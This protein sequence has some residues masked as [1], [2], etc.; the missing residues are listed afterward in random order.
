MCWSTGIKFTLAESFDKNYQGKYSY[1]SH[2]FRAIIVS[3]N[4]ELVAGGGGWVSQ[5]R[6]LCMST[7]ELQYLS[8]YRLYQAT[9]QP[10][11]QATTPELNWFR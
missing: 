9:L 11:V 6:F 10:Y 5:D 1:E 8:R 2:S 4:L 7:S 3:A